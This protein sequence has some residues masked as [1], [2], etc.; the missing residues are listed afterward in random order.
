MATEAER[1]VVILDASRELGLS[2]IKWALLGLPLKPGD[3]LILLGILHQVN[4]PSTL[5][6]MGAGKL[7]KNSCV[8]VLEK[9]KEKTIDM[10]SK[11]LD[12]SHLNAFA[13]CPS[14]QF[15]LSPFPY[16]PFHF[17]FLSGV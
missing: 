6:F 5:S 11:H 17:F 13:N 9:E 3:K 4:N 7:S 14:A 10:I 15:L 12:E 16:L 1:V 8:F 2:T